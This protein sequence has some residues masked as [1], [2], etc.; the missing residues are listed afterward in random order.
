M[1]KMPHEG[2]KENLLKIANELYEDAFNVNAY[3]S[4]MMQYREMREKYKEEMNLSPG[5]YNVTYNS[6]EYS[7]FMK[8][9]TLYESS[10]KV[11]SI[12]TL[13]KDCR[14]YLYILDKESEKSDASKDA[15]LEQH[16]F[17]HYLKHAEECF[18]KDEVAKQR[19]QLKNLGITNWETVPVTMYFTYSELMKLY[20]K[21][22]NSLKTIAENVSNQRNKV[23]A[24]NDKKC[25]LSDDQVWKEYPV[26]YLD[27]KELIDFALETTISVIEMLTG[28]IRAEN[29][30]NIDDLK[31][32]LWRARLGL[33]CNE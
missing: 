18:Y 22:L 12:E 21:R 2:A 27:M 3:Y 9:A 23:Y 8:L 13:I 10:G 29:C 16:K 28:T 20:K 32:T 31:I 11:A 15:V 6:L 26:N 7:C 1:C 4:V 24:H 5:F 25:I 17:K 14:N 30:V 19:E 33:K